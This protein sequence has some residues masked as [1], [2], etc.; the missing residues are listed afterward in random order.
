MARSTYDQV[1]NDNL[2][3]L[4]T[5]ACPT[6]EHFLE[7]RD[8]QVSQWGADEGAVEGHLGHTAS[9]VMAMLVAVFRDPRREE[10]LQSSECA[11]GEHLGAKRVFL[12]L[13]QVPL[14]FTL[15]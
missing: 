10:L 2:H 9:E 4:C 1:G 14:S 3:D 5:Q 7:N 6:C 8:H 11:G 13:L 12:E 15:A